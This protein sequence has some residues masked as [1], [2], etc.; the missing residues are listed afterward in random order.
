MGDLVRTLVL[1]GMLSGTQPITMMGLLLVMGGAT[2]RSNGLA[3]VSGAFA[4]QAGLLLGASAL[5]GGTVSQGSDTG[6]TFIGVRIA[7]GLA[8]FAFGLLLRRP[9]GKPIPEIPHALARLQDIGP[10]RSFVAGIVVADYQGPVIASFALTSSSVA[11]AGRL[12]GLG[13]YALIASGLPL[14]LMVWTTFSQRARERVTRLTTW[15]LHHRRT[16]ASWFTLV[17]GALLVVDS[18]YMLAVV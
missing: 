2:P 16:I 9:P 15:V 1:C 17:G 13:V 8:L 7:L 6:R 18:V 5:F 12:A 3:F 14:A 11:F 4:V 10:G